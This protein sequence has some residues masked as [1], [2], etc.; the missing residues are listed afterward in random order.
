[1]VLSKLVGLV[2]HRQAA[3][4][5]GALAQPGALVAPG[6]PID[7]C[8]AAPINE[9]LRVQS[10]RRRGAA[11]AEARAGVSHLRGGVCRR[12]G[13]HLRLCNRFR[14]ISHQQPLCC[15]LELF[16]CSYSIC[17]AI[18]SRAGNTTSHRAHTNERPP[19]QAAFGWGTSLVC[20]L[21]LRH[22][23]ASLPASD[24]PA[25]RSSRMPMGREAEEDFRGGAQISLSLF[26]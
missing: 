24:Q 18:L 19:Q 14:L 5:A 13:L 9:R 21:R 2:L 15:V 10:V 1:M 8:A 23:Q 6:R 3:G 11:A 12:L 4:G 17:S 7:T 16:Y 26:V 25:E 20:R 22:K